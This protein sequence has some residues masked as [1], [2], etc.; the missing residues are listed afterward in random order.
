MAEVLGGI[1]ESGR[2]V[3]LILGLMVLEGAV[4]ALHRR[5]TGRGVPIGGLIAFLLAGACL[6]LALRGALV[7]A[8]WGW[9]A[10]PL[11]GALVAHLADLRLR[12]RG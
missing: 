2:V 4:L 5:R 12:W 7:G 9:I 1:F 8:W 3:D 11:A 6:L 10:L